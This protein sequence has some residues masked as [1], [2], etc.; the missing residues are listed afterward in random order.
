MPEPAVAGGEVVAVPE[1]LVSGLSC[2]ID[3]DLSFSAVIFRMTAV[4]VKESGLDEEA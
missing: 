2:T 3:F 1:S 4:G